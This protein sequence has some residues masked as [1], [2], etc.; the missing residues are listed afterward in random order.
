MTISDV[1]LS[2][3]EYVTRSSR[4]LCALSFSHVSAVFQS[5]IR[6][7]SVMCPLSFSH[8]SAVLQLYNEARE[9]CLQVYGECSLLI[10]RLYINIG[11]VYED[12]SDYVKAFNYFMRW[13]RVSEMILGPHHP[14]TL[15]AKGVLKEPR[16]SLV[17]ERLKENSNDAEGRV[18]GDNQD[19][20]GRAVGDN[21]DTTGRPVGDNQDAAIDEESINQEVSELLEYNSDDGTYD[22]NLSDTV[23][24]EDIDVD[25]DIDDHGGENNMLHVTTE[26]QQAINQLLRRALGELNNSGP[27]VAEL[28]L[29]NRL[30]E[31]DGTTDED[32]EDED[33]EDTDTEIDTNQC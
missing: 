25:S 19:A 13:A 5:C 20:T 23:T 4:N 29:D 12:N 8:V 33:E 32:T 7:L 28:Q 2:I 21:Q 11:I 18:V 6:C 15:R 1:I 24:R 17:A 3:F 26:L 9:L 31:S 10:S 30:E 14:K 16:Y 22:A 27:S